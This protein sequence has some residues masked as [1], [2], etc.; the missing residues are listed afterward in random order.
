MDWLAS[1]TRLHGQVRGSWLAS[2][3]CVWHLGCGS[4][5]GQA[6]RGMEVSPQEFTLHVWHNARMEGGEPIRNP[7]NV[8]MIV[9]PYI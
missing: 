2:K 5:N 4:A 9:V 8:G 3:R 6:A 1:W 7:I